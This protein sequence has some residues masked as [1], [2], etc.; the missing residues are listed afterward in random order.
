MQEK[1]T[2]ESICLIV[3]PRAGGGRAGAQIGKLR[4]WVTQYFEQAEIVLTEAPGHATHL[5]AEAA[6]RGTNIVAAVGGD[7]TCHEVVNGLFEDEKPIDP[8]C[9]FTVIPFGTGSDLVRSLRMPRRTEEALAVAASGTTR[10]TDLGVAEFTTESGKRSEL[11]VNVAGFGAN[12]EVA[13]R[14]NQSSKRLGGMVTFVGATLRTLA[15]YKPQPVRITAKTAEGVQIWEDELLS[16]FVANGHY[17]GSGM[18]VGADG[19]MSDGQFETTL[20]RPT[21]PLQT[22]RDF[23]KLYNGDLAISM[24]VTRLVCAEIS[25]EPTEPSPVTIELDGE[26]CGQLPATFRILPRVLPVRAAW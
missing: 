4:R 19:D 20:L 13:R 6:H 17:C 26:S 3:N 7:G 23:P 12:G 14:S 1:N 8:S 15:S 11:F 25:A 22:A 21:S 10:M 2:S 9:I 18:W 24:G 16:A 5:A